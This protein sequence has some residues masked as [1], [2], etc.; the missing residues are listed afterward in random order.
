MRDECDTSVHYVLAVILVRFKPSPDNNNKKE[1]REKESK[2]CVSVFVKIKENSDACNFIED[3]VRVKTERRKSNGF[4][5]YRT[6]ENGLISHIN[7]L[8]PCGVRLLCGFLLFF[9]RSI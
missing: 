1:N 9:V 5:F 2:M 8:I 3:P 4:L 6:P 7:V